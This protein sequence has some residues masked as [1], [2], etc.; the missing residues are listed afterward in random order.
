MRIRRA[1]SLL[2]ASLVVLVLDRG[3]QGAAEPATDDWSWLE[4]DGWKVVER[5]LP[6]REDV[7][8]A[9]T[10]RS[11]R[12][13]YYDVKEQYFQISVTPRGRALTAD[14]VIPLEKSIQEQLLELHM[15][16]PGATPEE[17]SGRLRVKRAELTESECPAVRRQLDQLSEIR[18]APPTR[19]VIVLHP[20][21]YRVVIRFGDG[22]LDVTLFDGNH[23]LVRW[24]VS[25]YEAFVACADRK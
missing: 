1:G 16:D 17:L 3:I 8:T 6:V 7:G 19:D 13:L 5:M 24:A 9:A 4:D 21:V 15:A 10:F 11:Y 12:D 25:T 2:A 14:V 23:P 20:M 18:F 22:D